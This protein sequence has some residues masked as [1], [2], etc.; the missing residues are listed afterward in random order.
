MN[1]DTDTNSHPNVIGDLRSLVAMSIRYQTVYADP[2]W[3]CSNES[4]RAAAI[5]HYPRMSLSDIC[6]E[7]ASQLVIG[8]AHLHLSTTNAFLREAFEAIAAWGFVNKSC[9]IW[10]KPQLGM[11]NYLRVSHEFLLLGVRGALTFADRTMRSWM[12]APRTVHSR[13]PYRVRQ[14]IEQVSLRPYLEL[15][16]HEEIPMSPWTVYGNE[17]ERGMF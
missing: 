4:S 8:D 5:S 12:L 15:Y 1:S 2:P 6:A 16:G 7:P 17:V 14:L 11:G 10:V 3:S 9:L 13:I